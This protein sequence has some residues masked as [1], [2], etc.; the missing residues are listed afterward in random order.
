MEAACPSQMWAMQEAFACLLTTVLNHLQ[1]GVWPGGVVWRGSEE[2]RELVQGWPCP[3]AEPQLGPPLE[4]FFKFK[5]PWVCFLW[6]ALSICV[7]DQHWT[8]SFY[9][10]TCRIHYFS[11]GGGIFPPRMQRCTPHQVSFMKFS[12]TFTW[13]FWTLPPPYTAGDKEPQI[14]KHICHSTMYG[15]QLLM[16]EASSGSRRERM[17]ENT[18]YGNIWLHWIILLFLALLIRNLFSGY[19]LTVTTYLAAL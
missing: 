16:E 17:R 13:V 12:S 3:M 9:D 2:G 6:T 19:H 1:N 7:S 18:V 14:M 10:V 5:E 4:P 15:D 8:Q 11:Y